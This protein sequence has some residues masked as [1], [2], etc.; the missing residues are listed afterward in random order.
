M[1]ASKQD[2]IGWFHKGA[3]DGHKR[4]VVWV[5]QFDYED[6]PEYTDL[7][8]ADLI[9]HVESKNGTNMQVMMEVYDLTGDLDEQMNERRVYR[10]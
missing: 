8:G 6:Y 4:M 7:T 2:L 10:Y 3:V 5:D 9:K 1:A